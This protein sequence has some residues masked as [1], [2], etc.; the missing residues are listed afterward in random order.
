[1]VNDKRRLWVGGLGALI[2]S[3]AFAAQAQESGGNDQVIGP[4]QL[5]DFRLPQRNGLG[6]RP[7]LAPAEAQP[8]R[9]VELAPPPPEAVAP[10]QAPPA[11]A[12]R[13]N[14][15]APAAAS[16][17]AR[18]PQNENRG[19]GQATAAP[20]P[21]ANPEQAPIPTAVAPAAPSSDVEAAPQDSPEGAE[22]A[23]RP[24]EAASGFNYWFLAVPAVLLALLGVFLVRRR[25]PGA[26]GMPAEVAPAAAPPPKPRPE[27]IKRPWLELGLKAERASFTDTEAVVNFELEI[28][29]SGASAARNLRIDVKMFNAGAEQDQEIG[30]FFKTAGRE[31]TKLNLPEV[32]AGVTGVIQGSVRMARDE[33]RATRLNERLL[34]VPVIAVNALYDWGENRTGQTSRSYLIGRELQESSEKMGAFRVDQGPRIWRTVGQRPHKLAKRV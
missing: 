2:L 25:R 24:A 14:A 4:P 1:M 29:N 16:P 3:A 22:T 31:S 18:S 19:P 8:T 21:A 15:P 11:P 27:P 20:G 32:E 23:A 5:K 33:M 17:P 10:R 30:T 13:Q 6:T 34:F 26:A 7:V 9:P 28:A 12:A